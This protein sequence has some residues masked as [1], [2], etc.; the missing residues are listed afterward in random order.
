MWRAHEG[1]ESS[2]RRE[3]S[4]RRDVMVGVGRG[5]CGGMWGVEDV[6]EGVAVQWGCNGGEWE[7]SGGVVRFASSQCVSV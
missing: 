4:S 7:C 2:R 3:G 1:G 6:S 5:T